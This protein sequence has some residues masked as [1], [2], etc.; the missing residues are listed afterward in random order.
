MNVR[1]GRFVYDKT[2][3]QI[4]EDFVKLQRTDPEDLVERHTRWEVRTGC[5]TPHKL[6]L[7]RSVRAGQ[8][9]SE[10]MHWKHRVRTSTRWWRSAQ[11]VLDRWKRDPHFLRAA[12]ARVDRATKNRT[13]TPDEL[14]Y[15]TI[16]TNSSLMTMTHFRASV[17]KYLSDTTG[18]GTVLDFSAGW[19]DRLTGFM[20]S[21]SVR[22]IHLIDPRPG[23]IACCRRQHAFV[24]STKHL[25][26]HQGGAEVVLPTL[27]SGTVDL[28]VS[29]PPYF[30]LEEYGETT[31][32]AQGQIRLKVDSVE[33]YLRVF[34]EPVLRHSARLL[35]SGGLL[36]L[37]I[38]DNPRADTIVCA[39][40]LAIAKTIPDL[41]FVGTA[42]LRKGSGFGLAAKD[43]TLTKAEP[44]YMWRKR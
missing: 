4:R 21:P 35:R 41:L 23:S 8:L 14:A 17:S 15:D 2:P 40:A 9:L 31:T 25:S 16:R 18:A 13:F 1:D 5:P 33:G 43:K 20:A 6:Y 11:E 44:I 22:H 24:G 28:I 39:P 38:D 10:C 27:P 26:L 37:N 7:F 3:A 32:E 12:A 34:L 42:G 30:N 19:G 29:S 36:A